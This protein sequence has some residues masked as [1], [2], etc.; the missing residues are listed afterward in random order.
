MTGNAKA[1]FISAVLWIITT[2]D[3]P[4]DI[5]ERYSD[6]SMLRQEALRL[7][8]AGYDATLV[9]GYIGIPEGDVLSPASRRNWSPKSVSDVDPEQVFDKDLRR[10][11]ERDRK[12]MTSFSPVL[13]GNGLLLMSYASP[14][15]ADILKHYRSLALTRMNMEYARSAQKESLSS[16]TLELFY[17]ASLDA[18][19]YQQRERGFLGGLE[20]CRKEPPLGHIKDP[21]GQF[22]TTQ[23]PWATLMDTLTRVGLNNRAAR[24]AVAIAGDVIIDPQ[25]INEPSPTRTFF[26]ETEARAKEQMADWT[27]MLKKF[28][29]TKRVSDIELDMLSWPGFQVTQSTVNDLL[30]LKE[31]QRA[32]F[33]SRMVQLSASEDVKNDLQSALAALD[34]GIARCGAN[35]AFKGILKT[36]KAVLAGVLADKKD[37]D[38][39]FRASEALFEA[40]SEDADTARKVI[41]EANDRVKTR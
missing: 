38:A 2:A 27:K 9:G 5:F 32:L 36:K 35:E 11:I 16:G 6:P 17:R 12:N 25:G 29:E 28:F 10:M 24:L 33:I 21:T 1:L 37:K 30:T 23:R 18:C 3:A 34:R 14:A 8:R 39:G 13:S 15:M 20:V 22:V 31:T 41:F 40:L 4:A 26:T 7:D 19:L